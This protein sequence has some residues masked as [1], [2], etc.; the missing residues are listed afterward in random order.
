VAGRKAL[1]VGSGAGGAMAAM[2]L[3]EAGYDVVVFEKGDN[4]FDDLAKPAPRSRFSSDELKADRHFAQPDPVAEPRTYRWH[5][6]DTEPRHVGAVQDLPQTVGGA[7]VHWDAKT[8]RFW[9]IDF[10]KLSLLGPIDGADV[11]DWPFSYADIAPVYDEVE[12]LIGVAGGADALPAEPTLRHAPRTKPLPMPGGPPQLAS[13]VAA[14]GCQKLEPPLHP[15]LA[16]M[17]INSSEYDGRPACNNCGQCS[18]HGCPILARVGALAPLRR[19]VTAGAE[20]RARSWV[21]EVAT[22]GR[23]ATGVSWIDDQGREHHESG[24]LVVL[25]CLAIETVRLAKL[26]ELPDPHGTIGTHFMQHWFTDGTGIFLDQRLHAHRG[27]STTH[28]VD[29]FADP[30]FPGARVAAQAAGLPYFRGGTLELGGTQFP[31]GEA[32]TYRYLL[33][34]LRPDKPFGT[35]FKQLMRSSVLRDR[36]CGIQMIGEDLPYCDNAVDLDPKVKDYRGYPVARITYSPRAH[37][38]AA[39]EFYR[40]YVAEILRRAG[41]DHV[42]AVPD[43]AS[44]AT[45]LAGNDVPTSAHIMGGMR[46]G[47][48]PAVSATDDEGRFHQLDNLFV[49]DGSVFPTSGAHNPTLTIMATALRNARRWVR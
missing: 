9:D 19:A 13:L 1:V 30:D 47:T 38:L 5:S 3:A 20:V 27:R 24:D 15:F 21:V 6:R 42:T 10:R 25:A 34:L 48:D 28:A 40:P 23:R 35:E 4:W 8:P 43:A 33:G 17:A 7:T 14:E 39:Q 29:D 26:S 11:A 49:A 41:A 36:M 31:L 46:M 18:N 37:E 45:P 16:P 12:D 32:N 2:V 22:S 44:D